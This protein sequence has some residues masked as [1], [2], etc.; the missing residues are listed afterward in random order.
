M[1]DHR[2]LARLGFALMVGSIAGCGV[3]FGVVGITARS[4]GD[5]ELE[6]VAPNPPNA[7]GTCAPRRDTDDPVTHAALDERCSAMVSS[8]GR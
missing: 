2:N 1:L 8:S 4:S 7:T 3:S 6:I 5:A